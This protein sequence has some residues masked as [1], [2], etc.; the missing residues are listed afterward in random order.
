M[1]SIFGVTASYGRHHSSRGCSLVVSEQWAHFETELLIL[2]L[3][4][5][6]AWIYNHIL[7]QNL[8]FSTR[9]SSRTFHYTVWANLK[10]GP[11]S[12]DHSGS[13]HQATK[14][15]KFT[16]WTLN[17]FFRSHH[18]IT[19]SQWEMNRKEGK[20]SPLILE[21]L[22]FA[23]HFLLHNIIWSFQIWNSQCQCFQ[24]T[25]PVAAEINSSLHSVWPLR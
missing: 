17:A 4:G 23:T 8:N 22:P 25:K 11:R 13:Q 2:A 6:K 10:V 5:G 18:W 14:I 20:V 15:Q 21:L 24:K 16:W 12:E 1:H 9:S 7:I 19:R 3:A